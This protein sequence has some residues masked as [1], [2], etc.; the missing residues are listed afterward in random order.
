MRAFAVLTDG[1]VV[2][3][4][5]FENISHLQLFML[6]KGTKFSPFLPFFRESDLE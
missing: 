3:E 2:L 1:A 6:C 5:S 4:Q